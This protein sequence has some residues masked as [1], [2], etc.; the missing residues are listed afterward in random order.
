MCNRGHRHNP[1]ACFMPD[2]VLQQIALNGKKA[3]RQAALETMAVDQSIRTIRAVRLAAPV[4]AIPAPAMRLIGG[5]KR[6]S[7]FDTHNSFNLPGTLIRSEGGAPTNDPPADEAYDGLGA[8]Y[9]LFWEV[10]QR[11]SIDNAGMELIATV[12][13]GSDYNN[14]FWNSTQMVFGDGDGELFNRFTIVVDI[15]GHELT[16]GVT[17]HESQ[18][19]YEYQPGALNESMS[20]VFGSL[21]KQWVLQQTA[22][23]ADWLIGE[24][25]WGPNVQGRALRD[26]ANPGT[27]YDD[28]LVGKDPQP[29][30]MNDFVETAADN[31]GVHINSGIANRAFYLVATELGGYAWERA[32]RIWYD[33][34]RDPRLEPNAQFSRFAWLT[35]ENAGSRYGTGSAEQQAVRSAWSSVGI[36]PA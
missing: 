6:R 20:D 7:I 29:G 10:Y 28:D 11:D 31:G 14:A 23:Q 26:M 3:Q 32:G 13:F 35:V 27:A 9:D 30:H 25:I 19:I 22:D 21:V 8:T 15:M 34:L 33:A 17:E 36:A 1:R 12:H 2:H 4:R 24:G 18:L 5:Q 16:H